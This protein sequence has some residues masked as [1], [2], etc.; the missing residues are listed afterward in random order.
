MTRLLSPA[1][2]G[3]PSSRPGSPI[4]RIRSVLVSSVCSAAA[5]QQPSLLHGAGNGILTIAQ[6]DVAARDLR[7]GKLS[8]QE[9]EE[10]LQ[11]LLSIKSIEALPSRP[12]QMERKPEVEQRHLVSL[13]GLIGIGRQSVLDPPEGDHRVDATRPRPEAEAKHWP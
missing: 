4:S 10:C 6:G 5:P 9:V 8:S 13:V 7:L 3:Y 2:E 1:V 11:K 12:P